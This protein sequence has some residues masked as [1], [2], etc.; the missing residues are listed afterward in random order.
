[1]TEDSEPEPAD[2]DAWAQGCVPLVI[3]S[4]PLQPI[5]PKVVWQISFT[6]LAERL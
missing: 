2:P 1:M 4:Q 5:S 3:P 6:K